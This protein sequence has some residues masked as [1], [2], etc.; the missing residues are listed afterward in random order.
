MKHLKPLTLA[1]SL[2][3]FPMPAVS[4]ESPMPAP[5]G[6]LGIGTSVIDSVPGVSS[7]FGGGGSA[8]ESTQ[9][10]HMALHEIGNAARLAQLVTNNENWAL[11]LIKMSG[12]EAGALAR[13]VHQ[14]MGQ[15]ASVKRSVEEIIEDPA[16]SGPYL[17]HLEYR[18]LQIERSLGRI[19][20]VALGMGV[21]EERAAASAAANSALVQRN[22][23]V[24]GGTEAAQINNELIAVGNDMNQQQLVVSQEI[25]RQMMREEAKATEEKMLANERFCAF[26]PNSS[27][28]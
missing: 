6:L 17:R 27:H 16:G 4:Q 11:Q 26:F 18:A 3:A 22:M 10:M 14:L 1:A 24:H 20:D 5:S 28:C 21:I 19:E 13:N 23:H 2:L 9:K 12:T 25:L 8:R 7:I 15:L